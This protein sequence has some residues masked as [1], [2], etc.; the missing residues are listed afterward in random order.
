MNLVSQWLWL[1]L[2]TLPAILLLHLLRERSKR[3]PIS[4]LELWRWLEKE[5]RGPR[6]RRLP[7]TWVLL[8]QLLAALGLNVALSRPT[9]TWARLLPA[10]Q[11][12]IFVVDTSGSMG[13]SD[14]P[15][16]RL[17]QA[18]ASAGARLATL[19]ETD[20]ATLITAGP[21]ARQL[22]SADT[23]GLN[24]VAG[25]LAGL[26][27]AGDGSDWAGALAL[28]AAAVEPDYTNTIIVYTDGAFTFSADTE[29]PALPAEVELKLVGQPIGNQAVVTLAV[30]PS[31][32]GAVQVFARLANFANAP[33]ERSLTLFADGSVRDELPVLLPAS[34]VTEQAW[35]LPPGVTNLSVQLGGG[36]VL[37]ADDVAAVGVLAGGQLQA[38]LVAADP[39]AETTLA[40]Q[41]SLR[42]L[43]DLALNTVSPDNYAAYEQYD[44]TVFHGWLPPAWPRG[45][46]LVVAPPTGA[47]LLNA[48]PPTKVG[49]LPA[50]VA[51]N[52][53]VDVDLS[54]VNFGNTARLAAP[55]WLTPVLTD[56]D[57]QTLIWHGATEGSRVVV[58]AFGLQ[59]GNLARRTAFPVLVANAVAEVA[60]PPLPAA[61]TLGQ[62]V[63][64]PPAHRLPTLTL[65]DPNGGE[66]T[67]T[68]SR[69]PQYTDTYLPGLYR[70]RGLTINGQGWEG[71]F[72]ANA[73]SASE[74]DLRV[75]AQPVL[76]AIAA[77]GTPPPVA[78]NPPWNLW[79]YL[80][81]AVL[82][83]MVLE[84]WL[85]WR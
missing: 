44:L 64:L 55:P 60:P 67:L 29:Q 3:Q 54:H 75:S 31:A 69:A 62:P 57:G 4:S 72:G 81:L 13:A 7:V 26:R 20:R 39:T 46:V 58:F 73:G 24:A 36:D 2:L 56:A 40:L 42:S 17:A 21:V 61:V 30:R 28:A 15:P 48:Q 6:L 52:L 68:S 9:F 18:Q 41:R 84:A 74:S 50:L 38:V 85:A 43:P 70:L 33:V 53:L 25:P 82:G 51:D 22:G 16:T 76:T 66:H 47:S 37:A 77:A 79:P 12:L 45:G 59:P 78:G 5:L 49:D 34:G 35:T 23:A 8:L 83:V 63:E 19:G 80:V 27:A 11:H 32:S 71:S 14:A 10:R 1:G 65:T